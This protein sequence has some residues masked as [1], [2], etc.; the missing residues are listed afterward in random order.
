MFAHTF[1]EGLGKEKDNFGRAGWERKLLEKLAEV[2]LRS[3][4]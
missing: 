3:M 1:R 2:F 4:A